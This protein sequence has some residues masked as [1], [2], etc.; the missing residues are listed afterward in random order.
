MY[1]KTQL[2]RGNLIYR[3]KAGWELKTS[4]ILDCNFYN[5]HKIVIVL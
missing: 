2:W 5:Q 1:N 4:V 3:N